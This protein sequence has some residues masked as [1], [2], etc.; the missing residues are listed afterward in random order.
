MQL[1]ERAEPKLVPKSRSQYH[2]RVELSEQ[3]YRA[4][5]I[6]YDDQLLRGAR[7]AGDVIIGRLRI[8]YRGVREKNR[9][10]VEHAEYVF[11]PPRSRLVEGPSVCGEE[12]LRHVREVRRECAGEPGLGAVQ[13]YDVRLRTSHKPVKLCESAKVPADPDIASES[14]DKF[15]CDTFRPETPGE[16]ALTTS[17]DSDQKTLIL[18]RASEVED[19]P[20]GSAPVGF[21]NDEEY[22]TAAGNFHAFASVL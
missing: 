6:V 11:L 12:Y 2:A 19:V 8:A 1:A 10:M 20:L 5:A 18:G 17:S 16:L 9:R 4:H 15:D 14:C 7:H 22:L 3:V 21:S 13:V